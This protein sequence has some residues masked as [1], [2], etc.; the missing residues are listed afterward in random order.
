[1]E[2]ET[3]Q[4]QLRMGLN[5]TLG[6]PL[7]NSNVASFDANVTL[8]P[9]GDSAT[10]SDVSITLDESL[11]RNV[12]HCC[13][14]CR[15]AAAPPAVDAPAAVGTAAGPLA[16]VAPACAA[17]ARCLGCG[18][19]QRTHRKRLCAPVLRIPPRSARRLSA[20]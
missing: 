6:S 18:T 2:G 7:P 10:F 15:A 13:C 14:C 1:M 4:Y 5:C 9:D 20:T 12:R 11:T 3:A 8:G 19:N 16:C 17:A